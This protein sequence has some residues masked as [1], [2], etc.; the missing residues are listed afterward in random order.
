MKVLMLYP[1]IRHESLVP[2]S[3]SLLSRILKNHGFT[4]D[5]F[6]STD[7][8][9]DLGM[10][11][12]DRVKKENL[13]VIPTKA[14]QRNSKGDVIGGIKKK[15]QGFSPD[16][17]AVTSTESTFPLAVTLLRAVREEMRIPT[18]LGGVF[19][20]FAPALALRY[21][22]IDMCVVGE[23]E[24]TLLALA[25]AMDRGEDFSSLPGLWVKERDGGIKKNPQARPV[26]INENPTDLDISLFDDHRLYRP[27]GG[28][29]YRMLSVETHRGCPYTCAFCNSPA[30]NELFGL[31]EFFRK[32]K[33]EKV[34]EEILYYKRVF[35]IEYVFFWA[36]TFF[37]FSPAEFDAFIEMYQDIK[38]PF[39]CQTRPETVM[40]RKDRIRQLMNIGLHR[41][42]FGLE[43][44]N[45]QFRKEVVGREMSNQL[46]I[47][48]FALVAN[49]GIPFSVNNIIGF[50]DETRDL[51]FDTVRLNQHARAQSRSCSI[52]M[53]YQGT[54][55]HRL[56]VRRGYIQEDSICP[57][58]NDEA[59][60]NMSSLSREEIMGLRRTF[61]LYVGFPEP[62]WPEIREA[63]ADTDEGK[64]KLEELRKEFLAT[65]MPGVP[66]LYEAIKQPS[67][68]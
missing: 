20:T 19:A 16:L 11:D 56:A 54:A 24:H 34:R 30:Q 18:V 26:D 44:G 48:A 49:T 15:V 7:Y 17:I 28:K 13:L 22:E 21:P 63:E 59:F 51:V 43:H 57:S 1:N 33:P 41:M 36:D 9:I 64:R 50:P 6:D 14:V 61:P 35:G 45:E 65:H 60:M 25:R 31:S 53:P 38:L 23:G 67:V 46:L 2:P 39:W 3:V 68:S 32:K 10:V 29:V 12:A 66:E 47:D 52:F 62:R 58:N 37:A 8:E 55:L 5:I 42:S 4:V 27:M 40:T